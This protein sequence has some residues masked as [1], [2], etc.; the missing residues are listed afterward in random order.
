M[1]ELSKGC[2][3]VVIGAIAATTVYGIVAPPAASAAT[4]TLDTS[5]NNSGTFVYTGTFDAVN[6]TTTGLYTIAAFGAQ[7]G[8]GIG[9]NS[10]GL[11]GKSQA[12]FNLTAGSHLSI[13]VGGQGRDNL[14]GGSGG[15]ETYVELV[16]DVYTLLLRAGGGGGGG[17]SIIGSGPGSYGG[18][19]SGGG[20]G[21]GLG[22]NGGGLGGTLVGSSYSGN[23]GNGLG[24]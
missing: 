13:A 1:Y 16:T 6:I 7:G 19:P 3:Q 4:F 15:G 9:T 11:G 5:N 20:S 24:N 22:G 18:F 12:D 21:G 14:Y 17:G 10:G 8:T 2:A 23:G